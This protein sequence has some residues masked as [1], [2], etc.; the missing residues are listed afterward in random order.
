MGM[1]LPNDGFYGGHWEFPG[2][3]IEAGETDETALARE[4]QEEL[5]CEI[6]S[7]EKF[8][9]LRWEYPTRS[10]EL[11][12]YIVTATPDDILKM[13]SS[14]HSTLGWFTPEEAL[15]MKILPANVEIV[16]KLMTR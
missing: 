5:G 9:I 14:A 16:R 8:E 13:N 6:L 7:F 11:R 3:K 10:V 1:R 15:K 12:F 4:F 2:G